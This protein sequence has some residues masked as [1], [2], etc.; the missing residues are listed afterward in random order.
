MTVTVKMDEDRQIS[1]GPRWSRGIDGIAAIGGIALFGLMLITVID[2][3]GRNMRVL[4]LQGVIEFS[5]ATVV[6][7][8]F[9][10]LAHCFN[11]AGHIVVDLATQNTSQRLNRTLDAS[12]HLVASVIYAAMAWLMWQDGL[13]R[14]LSGEVTDNLEWSPLVFTLPAVVGAVVASLTCVGLAIRGYAATR[15]THRFEESQ[16]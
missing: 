6:F 16:D 2:I 9:L 8:G 11:V 14:H 7:L 12:W 15:N 4:Y 5:T 1:M 10:G 3:V 13:G